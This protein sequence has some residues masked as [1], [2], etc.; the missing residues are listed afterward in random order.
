MNIEKIVPGVN[1]PSISLEEYT[2]YFSDFQ[3]KVNFYLLTTFSMF[4]YIG[5]HSLGEK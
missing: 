2:I 4:L 1:T 5:A 3:K